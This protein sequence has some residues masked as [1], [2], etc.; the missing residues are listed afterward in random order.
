M[1]AAAAKAASPK[2]A[3]VL[4][5]KAPL[6]AWDLAAVDKELGALAAY[7]DKVSS[8]GDPVTL[9]GLPSGP[10]GAALWGEEVAQ[11]RACL[12]ALG[13]PG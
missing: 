13:P 11:H 2:V 3:L 6:A 4:S 12:A 10:E 9:A 5:E 8:G 1:A 7:L